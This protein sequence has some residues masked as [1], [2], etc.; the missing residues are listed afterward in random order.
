[1]LLVVRR[2]LG[3]REELDVEVARCEAE[4]RRAVLAHD[5]PDVF[6]AELLRGTA[7]ARGTVVVGGDRKRPAAGHAVV[8]LEQPGRGD[9]GAVGVEALV[10]DVVHAHETA[11]R[12]VRELPETR[13]SDP[14]VDVRR[15]RRLH[16][17]QIGDLEGQVHAA[18][19]VEDVVHVRARADDAGAELVGLTQLEADALG[20]EAELCV[21]DPAPEQCEHA[22]LVSG[23]TGSLPGRKGAKE[24][25]VVA[26][27]GFGVA[28][29]AVPTRELDDLVDDAELVGVVDQTAVGSNLTVDPLPEPDVGLEGLG[30]REVA[31]CCTG[32]GGREQT[33]DHDRHDSL[34]GLPL[35]PVRSTAV[36]QNRSGNEAVSPLDQGATG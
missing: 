23:E 24:A 26:L 3:R 28:V 4:G 13:G 8:L 19:G 25:L 20:G 36:R 12:G 5:A 22:L 15:E 30:L 27:A 33:Q 10:D 17:R 21:R 6:R 2:D 35:E 29:R 34:H 31:P 9:R 18:Q 32:D 7:H 16:V 1:M 11:A 14:G